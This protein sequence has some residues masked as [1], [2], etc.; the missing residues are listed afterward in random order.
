MVVLK[1]VAGDAIIIMH[2]DLEVGLV[3][4]PASISLEGQASRANDSF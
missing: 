1:M 2:E 3:K 4:M